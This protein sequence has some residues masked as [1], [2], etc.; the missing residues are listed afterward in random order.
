VGSAALVHEH[1]AVE[2]HALHMH[3]VL[4]LLHCYHANISAA[5]QR[6]PQE[7]VPS[8]CPSTSTCTLLS[9]APKQRCPLLHSFQHPVVHLL[10]L[11]RHAHPLSSPRWGSPKLWFSGH[12]CSNAAAEEAYLWLHHW[13]SLWHSRLQQQGVAA[14]KRVRQQ[15][16][17]V[18]RA[19]R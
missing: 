14:Y 12:C 13:G 18:R 9:H 17:E 1:T 2:T 19:A 10:L 15:L 11:W 7:L 4:D 3:T 5:P 16:V 6:H 8:A